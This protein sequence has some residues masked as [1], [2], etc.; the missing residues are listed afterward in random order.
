MESNILVLDSNILTESNI[1]CMQ[2]IFHHD[3]ILRSWCILTFFKVD[4][5]KLFHQKVML[6]GEDPD[7]YSRL[8][9]RL[10]I[11]ILLPF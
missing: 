2:S 5:L 1:S 9:K 11:F 6:L 3:Q 4:I 10:V 8:F 7:Y